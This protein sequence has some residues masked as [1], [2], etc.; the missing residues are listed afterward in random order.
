MK[1]QHSAEDTVCKHGAEDTASQHGAEDTVSKHGNR[2]ERCSPRMLAMTV[3]TSKLQASAAI[4]TPPGR[5]STRKLDSTL[6]IRTM[7]PTGAPP[8]QTVDSVGR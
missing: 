7:Q 6:D 3:V 8:V 4:M 2:E 1:R 5:P